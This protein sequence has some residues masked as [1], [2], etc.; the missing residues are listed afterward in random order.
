VIV[1]VIYLI[2]RTIG[3][4]HYNYNFEMYKLYGIV[5]SDV[6][7]NVCLKLIMIGQQCAQVS[8]DSKT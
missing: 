6:D 2:E 8:I 5:A 4:R 3:L 1:V 7:E